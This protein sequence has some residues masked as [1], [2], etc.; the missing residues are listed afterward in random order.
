[1][2]INVM[3]DKCVVKILNTSKN[4]LPAFQ[5]AG[6]SG[7]DLYADIETPLVLEPHRVYGVPTGIYLELPVGFEA[8]VRARSGLALKHGITLVNGIGTIDSDYR[9]EI[10]VI[11]MN[12][13]EETYTIHPGDRIAQMV[14]VRYS[15]PEFVI[16]N[17][18]EALTP[19]DR[20][21]GGF[22]HSGQ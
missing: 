13:L 5:S 20:G 2:I 17:A 18:P 9:G 21:Q 11:L 16:V 1:M 6:A 22:G 8:Q 10:R 15:Q 12:L 19:T 3:T 4:P 14:F 7:V